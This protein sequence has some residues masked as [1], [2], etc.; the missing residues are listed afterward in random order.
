MDEETRRD[1]RPMMISTQQLPATLE[2]WEKNREKGGF[3]IASPGN[4]ASIWG[5][6]KK[7]QA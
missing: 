1:E 2:V 4:T 3:M 6:A 7:P 5:K